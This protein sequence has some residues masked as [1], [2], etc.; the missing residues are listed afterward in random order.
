MFVSAQMC[1]RASQLGGVVWEGTY[2]REH[3]SGGAFVRGRH[4]S[5][6]VCSDIQLDLRYQ[7]VTVA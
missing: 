7:L 2:P 3:L 1:E 5:G 4:L 6:G